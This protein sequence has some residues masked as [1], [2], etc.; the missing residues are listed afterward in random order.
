MINEQQPHQP[1]SQD[2]GVNAMHQMHYKLTS[3]PKTRFTSS[4]DVASMDVVTAATALLEII[5][6]HKM[7]DWSTNSAPS[8]PQLIETLRAFGYIY[9]RDYVVKF[10][11]I[12]ANFVP[13]YDVTFHVSHS[14]SPVETVLTHLALSH[15]AYVVEDDE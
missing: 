14:E 2:N 5:E 9:G 8:P 15:I 1:V 11:C 13:I 12:G 10:N 7:F 3:P 6:E 4:M